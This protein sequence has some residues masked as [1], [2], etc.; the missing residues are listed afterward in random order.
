M[1]LRK[2]EFVSQNINL[3]GV[4]VLPAGGGPFG[5]EFSGAKDPTIQKEL[6]PVARGSGKSLVFAGG[7]YCYLGQNNLHVLDEEKDRGR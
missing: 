4:F 1:D 7:S 2:I 6:I 3:E 5:M